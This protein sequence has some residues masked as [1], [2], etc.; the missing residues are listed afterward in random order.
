M[1]NKRG[2]WANKFSDLDNKHRVSA[3][4][5]KKLDNKHGLTR[6]YGSEIG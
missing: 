4:K 5:V 1:D 2:V 6:L 3:Y